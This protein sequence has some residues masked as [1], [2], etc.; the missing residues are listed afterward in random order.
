[1]SKHTCK[2]NITQLGQG[3]GPVA[4]WPEAAMQFKAT[5]PGK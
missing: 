5:I 3:E 2:L 4:E 1:M